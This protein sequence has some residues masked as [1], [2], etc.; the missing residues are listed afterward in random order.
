MKHKGQVAPSA[1]AE[2]TPTAPTPAPIPMHTLASRFCSESVTSLL[3][4]DLSIYL[5]IRLKMRNDH[6]FAKFRVKGDIYQYVS[7]A[8]LSTDVRTGNRENRQSI[9]LKL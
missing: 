2:P 4:C 6:N 7:H 1:T 5:I 9:A 3:L 8:K